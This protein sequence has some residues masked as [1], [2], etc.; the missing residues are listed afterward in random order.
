MVF[1]SE[2]QSPAHCWVLVEF[3]GCVLGSCVRSEVEVGC[4]VSVVGLVLL[5]LFV[6]FVSWGLWD[7][8]YLGIF[9]NIW[10]YLGIFGNLGVE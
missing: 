10:E 4:P 2:Y 6:F 7:L 8:E 3:W 1:G 5:V 9:G